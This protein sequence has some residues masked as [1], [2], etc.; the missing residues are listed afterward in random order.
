MAVFSLVLLCPLLRAWLRI[1]AIATMVAWRALAYLLPKKANAL[2]PAE[3]IVRLS[4]PGR[5]ALILNTEVAPHEASTELT[6]RPN[7]GS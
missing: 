1:L 2:D 7:S 6:F 3:E 5:V 4:P